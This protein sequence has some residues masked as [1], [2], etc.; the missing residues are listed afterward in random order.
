MIASENTDD[1]L[2]D[3]LLRQ[4]LATIRDEFRPHTWRAFWEVVVNGRA[5]S[6]VAADLDMQPGAVRV[7]KSRVLLR[8]R[9]ELGELPS[10]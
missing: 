6:D 2:L 8:L 7:A 5:P 9:Q 4:A 10:S 3:D 1:I